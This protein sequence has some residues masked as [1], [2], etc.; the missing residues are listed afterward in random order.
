[1]LIWNYNKVLDSV[2]GRKIPFRG[3]I[4]PSNISDYFVVSEAF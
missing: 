2:L 1:M 4:D 3:K